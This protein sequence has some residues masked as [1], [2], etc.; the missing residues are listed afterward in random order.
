MYETL[1]FAPGLDDG[2]GDGLSSEHVGLKEEQAVE[3]GAGDVGLGGEMDDHVGF[4]HQGVDEG[5]IADIAI[6]EAQA[7]MLSVQ[8]LLREIVG[9]AGIREGVDNHDPVFGIFGDKAID[10]V[11]ADES[12]TAGDENATHHEPC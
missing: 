3:D 12:S 11:G 9:R 5:R 2:I 10:K 7:R 6:P 8:H 4:V 1:D